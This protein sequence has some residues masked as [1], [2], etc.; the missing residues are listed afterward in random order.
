[1]TSQLGKQTITIYILPNISRFKGNQQTMK[2]CQLIEYHMRNILIEKSYRK[3]DG[4]TIS[5]PFSKKEIL[6]IS[7]D[8]QSKVLYSLFVMLSWGLSKYIEAKLETTCFYLIKGF[9]KNKKRPGTSFPAS[10][11][12]WFSNKN[13][14]LVIFNELT[15]LHFVVAFTSW[16]IGQYVYCNCLSTRLRGHKFWN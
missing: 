8:Q 5:K 9:F 12:G 13:V 6:S 3:C 7:L 4:D 11:S 1:M 10:L 15:K 2:F 14:Y 16:D